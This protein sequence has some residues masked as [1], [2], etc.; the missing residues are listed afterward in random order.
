MKRPLVHAARTVNY[1]SLSVGLI[2]FGPTLTHAQDA[3]AGSTDSNATDDRIA[4][5]VVTAQF[6]TQ[7]VRDV[8][9]A[10]SAVTAEMLQEKARPA[11]QT[12]GR[13]RRGWPFVLPGNMATPRP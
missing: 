6:L 4:E 7:N 12:S 2:L 10:I 3:A 8:P 5:V 9:I 13:P 11:S 1:V